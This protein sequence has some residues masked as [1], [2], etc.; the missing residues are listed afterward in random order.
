MRLQPP[1]G[2]VDEHLVEP[3]FRFAG[4]EGATD[5]ERPLKVRVHFGQH[6]EAA[7]DVETADHDGD[8]RG[9]K[10]PGDVER[11]RKLIRL[12]PD[13]PDH[14]EAAGLLDP[15]ADFFRP[16]ARVGF[17]KRG[18]D[19]VDVGAEDPALR[20]VGGESVEGG[21]GV[22]RYQRSKKLN[23]IAVVIVVG[24]LDQ[25]EFEPSRHRRPWVHSLRNLRS[26]RRSHPERSCRVN[27]RRAT[28]AWLV[29]C[30]SQIEG[31]RHPLP[32]V[33]EG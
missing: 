28:P 31:R 16:Y 7:R 19:N 15:P 1:V 20:A 5:V 29:T 4:E 18:D 6:G 8:A 13:Q 33:G 25:N 2:G 24:R 14:S 22:R 10:R 30:V 26:R 9:P 11:A 23:D 17:V 27:A 12:H 32:L 21:Q 3:A